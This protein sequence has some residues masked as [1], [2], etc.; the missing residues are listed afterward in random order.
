MNCSLRRGTST[1]IVFLS[2]F[3]EFSS[4]YDAVLVLQDKSIESQ[5]LA[6][7]ESIGHMQSRGAT[8]CKF[9]DS[10]APPC[11][12]GENVPLTN[13]A[14]ESSERLT[15]QNELDGLWPCKKAKVMEKTEEST[16]LLDSRSN[17][18]SGAVKT[19][20]D[21]RTPII[22][23]EPN[24]RIKALPEKFGVAIVDS[25]TRPSSNS[26]SGEANESTLMPDQLSQGQTLFDKPLSR[27]GEENLKCISEKSGFPPTGKYRGGWWSTVDGQR[28]K[29]IVP[30]IDHEGDKV[31]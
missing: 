24:F 13:N 10:E 30:E 9:P 21:V 4:I 18:T 6:G 15:F 3:I 14:N 1:T 5:H 31:L 12:L 22:E 7:P 29:E 28:R 2:I 17:E 16:L 8:D 26:L 27:N 20:F 23:E 19:G 11:G 25:I